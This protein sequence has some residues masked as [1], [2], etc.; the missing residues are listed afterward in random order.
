[1]QGIRFWAG[2]EWRVGVP[3]GPCAASATLPVAIARDP[4]SGAR[5]P[6]GHRQIMPVANPS[7]HK[8]PDVAVESCPKA[9]LAKRWPDVSVEGCR[10]SG[11]GGLTSG[12]EHARAWEGQPSP[13]PST[14]PAQLNQHPPSRPSIQLFPASFTMASRVIPPLIACVL[15]VGTAV[16]TFRTSSPPRRPSEL[17]LPHPDPS[18]P[19]CYRRP[20]SCPSRYASPPA[21]A[22]LPRAAARVVQ[23]VNRRNH[24]PG[25]RPPLSVR[26]TIKQQTTSLPLRL[27]TCSLCVHSGPSRHSR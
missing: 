14:R 1:M 26:I 4:D 27:T 12:P 13:H 25:G 8:Q 23:P 15:G 22:A 3:G 19:P 16:Y 20:T 5:E 2:D 6:R 24:A 7:A 18:R 9:M 11:S 21:A 17:S 10:F